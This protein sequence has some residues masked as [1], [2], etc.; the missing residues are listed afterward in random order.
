[1][2]L[3]NSVIS[4]N[5]AAI[6][7][8]LINSAGSFPPS[9]ATTTQLINVTITGNMASTTLTNA[10]AGGIWNDGTL[11]YSGG[12]VTEN[13]SW[14][15]SAL[16]NA[17]TTTLTNVNFIGNRAGGAIRR[18]NS[19]TLV[20]NGGANGDTSSLFAGSLFNIG[21]ATL[22]NVEFLENRADVGYIGM[23][24]P[25]SMGARS[26]LPPPGNGG[27]SSPYASGALNWGPV[28]GYGSSTPPSFFATPSADHI[29]AN[30]AVESG[31]SGSAVGSY[32]S[33]LPA[34][35]F[36]APSADQL[37]AGIAV[38]SDNPAAPAIAMPAP[39]PSCWPDQRER[40][41]ASLTDDGRLQVDVT[42][43]GAGNHLVSL[44]FL[45]G[46]LAAGDTLIHY[47]LPEQTAETDALPPF[48]LTLPP[49]TTTYTFFLQR[50]APD[51]GTTA[52]FLIVDSCGEWPAF[53]GG[54]YDA[55]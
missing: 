18:S 21:T 23:S 41:A 33:P 45:A 42:V 5:R 12:A 22:T 2:T 6:G 24:T 10:S 9:T 51:R 30:I 26:G 53:V 1:L 44:R 7:A 31:H 54:G 40:V 34:S 43:T 46:Q 27:T 17:G 47:A 32:G 28:G 35:P 39:G 48:T 4:D 50:A 25:H 38:G 15:A 3:T 37:P 13:I 8:G 49:G 52:S 55:L 36:A 14:F 16:F 19:G 29:P 20:Y 11:I